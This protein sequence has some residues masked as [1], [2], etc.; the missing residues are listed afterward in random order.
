[1]EDILMKIINYISRMV[2]CTILVV[3]F[4]TCYAAIVRIPCAPSEGEAQWFTVR[5]PGSDMQYVVKMRGTEVEGREELVTNWT[6]YVVDTSDFVSEPFVAVN[7]VVS[8]KG[9]GALAPD[10]EAII[11]DPGEAIQFR[12]KEPNDPNP[13][14]YV[15]VLELTREAVG[16][17]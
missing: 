12:M 4:N 15:A 14:K 5:S 11:C 17:E 3:M 1:L 2:V 7:C 13:K 6:D 8:R 16:I 10:K 9:T